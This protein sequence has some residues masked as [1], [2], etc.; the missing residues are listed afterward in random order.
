MEHIH[1]ADRFLTPAGYACGLGFSYQ[2]GDDKM[3]FYTYALPRRHAVRWI[4]EAGRGLG[5]QQLR[6]NARDEGEAFILTAFVPGLKAE[7]LKIQVLDDVLTIEGTFPGDETDYLLRELPA[8]SF[9]RELSLPS[10]LQPD[11]VEAKIADGILTLRLPKAETARPRT[12]K[13]NVN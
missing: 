11:K 12:I 13:I 10:A 7:D 8:G 3:T 5:H 6:L 9:R 4:A 2:T 1:C